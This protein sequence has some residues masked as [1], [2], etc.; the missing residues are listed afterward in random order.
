MTG[1]L[2]GLVRVDVERKEDEKE[3]D[4]EGM[5]GGEGKLR[6]CTSWQ[7]RELRRWVMGAEVGG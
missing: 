4:D 6:N 2:F 5:H 3:R 1:D 7:G